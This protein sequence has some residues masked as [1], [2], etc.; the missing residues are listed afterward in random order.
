M[1]PIS[2]LGAAFDADF[3]SRV[4]YAEVD[5]PEHEQQ[6]FAFRRVPDRVLDIRSHG[7]I[8]RR[9]HSKLALRRG[10]LTPFFIKPKIQ[11]SKPVGVIYNYT[12]E[13]RK[14]V[15]QDRRVCEV[16][17]IVDNSE[18]KASALDVDIILGVKTPDSD[19]IGAGYTGGY[20]STDG[21]RKLRRFFQTST[22]KV[23]ED[24]VDTLYGVAD[25][26]S[27][28][29]LSLRTSIP[30]GGGETAIIGYAVEGLGYVL[31]GEAAYELPLDHHVLV[32]VVSNNKYGELGRKYFQVSW[33][34]EKWDA[35]DFTEFKPTFLK[36]SG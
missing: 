18:G 14:G 5:Y 6:Y 7:H 11:I 29:L 16:Q 1:W 2:G 25:V 28:N 32:I 19:I 23:H 34:Q 35:P 9:N 17:V 31:L 13:V 10:L 8:H 36:R 30:K 24:E 4:K 27:E 22:L 33:H 21:N 26:L 20:I 15:K 12:F 3:W